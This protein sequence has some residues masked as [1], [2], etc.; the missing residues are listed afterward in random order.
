MAS[1]FKIGGA[2]SAGPLGP[3]GGSSTIDNASANQIVSGFGA[4]AA[5]Q[6]QS[7]SGVYDPF[8]ASGMASNPV[9]APQM[10]NMDGGGIIGKVE[11]GVI[12]TAQDAL[13]TIGIGKTRKQKDKEMQEKSLEQTMAQ[14]ASQAQ[15]A[16][17]AAEKEGSQGDDDQGN[18]A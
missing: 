10:P 8:S 15:Q 7:G 2:G 1:S 3:I 18:L 9:P 17:E 6:G 12:G 5:Q 11:Q 13:G 4:Y 14:S 16:A